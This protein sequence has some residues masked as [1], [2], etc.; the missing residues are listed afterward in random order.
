MSL[1]ALR[2]RRCGQ[3]A[4]TCGASSNGG[5]GQKFPSFHVFP[6]LSGIVFWPAPISSQHLRQRPVRFCEGRVGSAELIDVRIYPQALK[7]GRQ[8]AMPQEKVFLPVFGSERDIASMKSC[9]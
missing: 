7:T 4:G 3:R 5:T 6:P 1:R 2:D 8:A 9:L